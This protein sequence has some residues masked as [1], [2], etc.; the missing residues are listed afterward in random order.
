V[1]TA[2]RS[3]GSISGLQAK[4]QQEQ[5]LSATTQEKPLLSGFASNNQ[6]EGPE[7]ASPDAAVEKDASG[8]PLWPIVGLG[9]GVIVILIALLRQHHKRI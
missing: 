3:N 1:A 6:Q 5:Q 7:K 2:T 9:A 4:Q 8:M